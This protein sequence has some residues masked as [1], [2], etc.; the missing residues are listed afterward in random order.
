MRNLSLKI[1]YNG[2]NYHGYQVQKN[3]V[4]VQEVLQQRIEKLL[5]HRIELKGCSRTD[6]GVHA[7]EYFVSFKTENKIACN[8]LVLGLNAILP[9]DIAAKNC[10]EKP[11]SFHARYSVKSKEYVYKLLNNKY[12]DAINNGLICWYKWPLDVTSLN[13]LAQSFVGVHNFKG[14]CAKPNR[15]TDFT[16]TI[17]YFDIFKIDDIIYFRVSGNGFLYKMVRIMVGTLIEYSK[18]NKTKEELVQLIESRKRSLTAKP[19]PP[20]GLYLN[21]V[22]Y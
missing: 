13:E 15:R 1:S 12:P 9:A 7:N 11:L 20:E 14:F 21:K 6:T 19:M 5:K 3:V 2:K 10:E 18:K 4:T 22:V 16:R 17:F 8:K